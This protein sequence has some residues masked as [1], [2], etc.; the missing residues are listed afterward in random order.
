M[1]IGSNGG[2]ID[3]L[4]QN[5]LI[6]VN[7]PKAIFSFALV[8]CSDRKTIL[9]TNNSIGATSYLWNFGDGSTSTSSNPTHTYASNGTYTVILKA[10]NSITG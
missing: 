7:P 3:T 8:N 10:M 9:F 4:K 6:H 2:C 5:N 1:L